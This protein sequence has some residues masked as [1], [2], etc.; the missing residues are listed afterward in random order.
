[1]LKFLQFGWVNY[2]FNLVV[3]YVLSHRQR[4]SFIQRRARLAESV[5]DP[6]KRL[7][8]LLHCAD[9]TTD[10][11]Q[12]SEEIQE[13]WEERKEIDALHYEMVERYR[14]ER[15]TQGRFECSRKHQNY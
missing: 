12:S 2:Y 15:I 8:I 5:S 9:W 10:L 7:R 6:D 1:M 13:A 4:V 3:L 11:L 14:R